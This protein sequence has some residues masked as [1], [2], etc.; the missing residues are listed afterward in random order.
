MK[1]WNPKKVRNMIFL[2]FKG[3]FSGSRLIFGV[4]L[5]CLIFSDQTLQFPGHFAFLSTSKLSFRTRS[6][7]YSKQL[8]SQTWSLNGLGNEQLCP[9]C[10]GR[11]FLLSLSMQPLQR[12]WIWPANCHLFQQL[13]MIQNEKHHSR[14]KPPKN[15]KT[16]SKANLS[17]VSQVTHTIERKHAKTKQFHFCVLIRR[18]THQRDRVDPHAVRG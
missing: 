9:A 15:R 4:Y 13:L 17:K 14:R 10:F 8:C 7:D 5:Y 11:Y 16:H 12:A 6:L 1:V 18:D 3:C 2:F